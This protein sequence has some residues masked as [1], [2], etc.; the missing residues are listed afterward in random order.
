MT[1]RRSF[2]QLEAELTATKQELKQRKQAWQRQLQIAARVHASLLPKPIRHPQI[3]V[4]VRYVPADTVGGDYCQVLFP[5]ESLCYV[6]I[7]DV[8]GHGVGPALLATRVSSEVRRLVFQQL[9]PMEIVQRLNAFVFEH[10]SETNLMLSFFAAQFDL[11]RGIPTYSGAGHP[12]PLLI[13]HGSAAAEILESQNLLIGAR[14]ECL[15]DHAEDAQS[16]HRGDRVLL[17][18]DG[19]TETMDASRDMLGTAGLLRVA[20]NACAGSLFDMADGILAQVAAF[21]SGPP[22]DDIT[23]VIAELE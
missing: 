12:G 11:T 1:Q 6:T 23:L 4:D 22:Q 3:S 16:V 21:R 17:F 14:E 8:T 15:S 2:D 18:T 5:S 13:R 9:R 7:C 19:L 10:F 20:R